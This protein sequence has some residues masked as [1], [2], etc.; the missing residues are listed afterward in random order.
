ME[1]KDFN[2]TE[3]GNPIIGYDE[4]ENSNSIVL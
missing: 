2:L 4:T 1:L 3:E